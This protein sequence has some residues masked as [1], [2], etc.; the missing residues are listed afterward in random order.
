MTK[1]STSPATHSHRHSVLGIGNLAESDSPPELQAMIEKGLAKHK[2]GGSL[3]PKPEPESQFTVTHRVGRVFRGQ[4]R[5][6]V[7]HKC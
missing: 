7:T 5:L 1:L 2:K 4:P 3:W 6:A